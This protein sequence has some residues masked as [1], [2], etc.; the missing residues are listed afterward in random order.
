MNIIVQHKY[1]ASKKYISMDEDKNGK[2][3]TGIEMHI[4]VVEGKKEAIKSFSII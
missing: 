2:V 1:L 3:S 4:A